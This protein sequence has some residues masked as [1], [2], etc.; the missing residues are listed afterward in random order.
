M[1]LTNNVLKDEIQLYIEDAIYY[2]EDFL[3]NVPFV[4]TMGVL[5]V[6]SVIQKRLWD[7]FSHHTHIYFYIDFK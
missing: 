1:Y 7:P 4:W 6:K 3:Y 5:Y 2:D